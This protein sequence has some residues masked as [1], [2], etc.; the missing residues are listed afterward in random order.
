MSSPKGGQCW[1]V[2][3]VGQTLPFPWLILKSLLSF[4]YCACWYGSLFPLAFSVRSDL[5]RLCGM[6]GSCF[7]AVFGLMLNAANRQ[8]VVPRLLKSPVPCHEVM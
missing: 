6:R 4:L 7:W 5:G 3:L 8:P 1:L 2:G